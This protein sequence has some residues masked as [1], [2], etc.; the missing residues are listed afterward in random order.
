[1]STRQLYAPHILAL[2]ID[3]SSIE[4]PGNDTIIGR[5]GHPS[6]AQP[7]V[8]LD[9]FDAQEEG[10]SRRHIRLRRA[11]T[12]VFVTDLGSTNGTQ[13]NGERLKPDVEYPLRDGDQLKLGNLKV[14]VLFR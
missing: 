14:T 13:L 12:L 3:A 6:E 2:Q 11:D 1:M 5:T 7:D 9:Q 8:N 10:V 4:L